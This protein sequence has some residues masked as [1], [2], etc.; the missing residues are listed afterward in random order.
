MS[1]LPIL[2]IAGLV[3]AGLLYALRPPTIFVVR[4]VGGEPV[5]AA[6]CD[7][8]PQGLGDGRLIDRRAA[9]ARVRCHELVL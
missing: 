1:S 9:A 5:I 3:I 6:V 7:R 4:V 2:I 8:E